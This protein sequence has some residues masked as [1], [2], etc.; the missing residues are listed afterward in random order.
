MEFMSGEL[1]TSGLAFIDWLARHGVPVTGMSM[2]WTLIQLSI[3]VFAYLLSVY[4]AGKLTPGIEA[5]IR[6]IRGNPRLTRILALILRRI[7]WICLAIFFWIA[8]GVLRG[9]TWPSHSYIIIVAAKLATAWVVISILSRA[10][11]NKFMANIVAGSVWGVTAL[12]LAGLLQET[13]GVLD[14]AGVTLAG[15]RV[16]PLLVIKAILIISVMIWLALVVG[17]FIAWR[18]HAIDGI[19][20]SIQVLI[21]KLVKTLL[22]ITAIMASLSIVG[23]DLT[24][25]AVFS[26]ALGIGI[27][28]GFQKVVSNLISG[29]ILLMDKTIEPGDVITVDDTYG[30]INEFAALNTSVISR[31][32]REY[33]IPNEDLITSQVINWS[34]TDDLVRLDLEFSTSYN[35]DPHQVRQIARDAAAQ[36][37]RVLKT[38]AP[39]CHITGFG[40]SAIDYKARFWISDPHKGTVNVRGD[41]F[42]MLWDAFK[43]HGIEIPYPH[44]DVAMRGPIQ[45]DLV[46]A[47]KQVKKPEK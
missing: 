8:W 47:P 22:M 35:A 31:D 23:I 6:E 46:R 45:V 26:G 24:V 20:P 19:S 12:S 5:R 10:I 37:E 28:F 32:G 44:R 7:K 4:I 18:V 16:T 15:L 38:P 39:V 33:L 3:I 9:L 2:N 29:V 13:L 17:R 1:S 40:D 11:R 43:E 21:S 25:L 30:R 42:L 41:V 34:Y 36:H 14:S 27:G